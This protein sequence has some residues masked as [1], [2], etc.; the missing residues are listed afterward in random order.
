MVK[1]RYHGDLH[2]GQALIAG[3]D[4]IVTDFE[5]EPARPLA[6]RR[7]KHCPLRD[8]AG[9]LRSFSYAAA[10]T[11]ERLAGEHTAKRERIA[12]VLARWETRTGEAFLQGYLEAAADP[13]DPAAARALI[14]L[15][16][17]EK[18][19][20]EL[21]YELAHRPDWVKVPLR[22]LLAV[23]NVTRPASDTTVATQP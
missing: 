8:V 22:G 3:G 20:Y 21:R 6:E 9:M 5:G 17:L 14:D 16:M 2:L 19:L 13:A 4:F 15:F 7:R 10:T 18:A 23:L 1:T 12:A 11:E